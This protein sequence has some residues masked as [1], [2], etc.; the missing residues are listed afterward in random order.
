[1][2]RRK[3]EEAWCGGSGDETKPDPLLHKREDFIAE[4]GLACETIRKPSRLV[5]TTLICL[6]VIFLHG[7]GD[8]G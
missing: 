5:S 4:V 8:T 1:M 7:L 2:P 3:V 6:Q